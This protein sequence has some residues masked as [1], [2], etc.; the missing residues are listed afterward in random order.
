MDQ[1]RIILIKV[2][3]RPTL[4]TGFDHVA[5]LENI[6]RPWSVYGTSTTRFRSNDSPANEAAQARQTGTG[7][8]HNP[9]VRLPLPQAL[10]LSA[11][12]R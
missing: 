5:G 11:C 10:I 6:L 9:S 1:W 12:P 2:P 7:R 3:R 8:S 4:P